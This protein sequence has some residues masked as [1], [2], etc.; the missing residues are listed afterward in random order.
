MVKKWE[1]AIQQEYQM[2]AF[3]YLFPHLKKASQR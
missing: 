3:G 2:S 1:L